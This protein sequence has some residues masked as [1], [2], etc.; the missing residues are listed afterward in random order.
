MR[1]ATLHKRRSNS[2]FVPNVTGSW[3]R[4][5]LEGAWGGSRMRT[6]AVRAGMERTWSGQRVD[7]ERTESGH[8][9]D[10]ERTES[11][12]K[13]G[14][15]TVR[16]AGRQALPASA[17][18][19]KSCHRT[20]RMHTGIRGET[21]SHEGTMAQWHEGWCRA[22]ASMG[23]I[24]SGETLPG[25]AHGKVGKRAH[26]EECAGGGLQEEGGIA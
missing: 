6:A 15:M 10:I 25:N 21:G 23:G 16:A 13:T 4:G 9:A 22:S 2:R 8:G 20:M 24:A 19:L 7:I 26:G 11:G 12:E 17:L 18:K 14:I 5:G 3:Q 1:K